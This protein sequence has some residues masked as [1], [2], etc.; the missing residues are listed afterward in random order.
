MKKLS[1]PP[2]FCL[3]LLI[4]DEK[5]NCT[6]LLCH[7]L[8]LGFVSFFLFLCLPFFFFFFLQSVLGLWSWS[9]AQSALRK[10]IPTTVYSKS[11]SILSILFYSTWKPM[12]QFLII[13]S[14]RPSSFHSPDNLWSR[15]FAT[16]FSPS[17]PRLRSI[18]SLQP[19]DLIWTCSLAWLVLSWR[20]QIRKTQPS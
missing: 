7:G 16:G 2:V 12:A 10:I 19:V 8:G 13:Y 11:H 14:H 3:A 1:Q 5:G 15:H 9:C 4:L 6:F 17:Y 20:A 18:S